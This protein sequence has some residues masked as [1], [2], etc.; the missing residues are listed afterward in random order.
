M[1]QGAIIYFQ[2]QT[3]QKP[4]EII[5]L[6]QVIDIRREEEQRIN[7]TAPPNKKKRKSV[8]IT[9]ADKPKDWVHV[10]EIHT[11]SRVYRL[12]SDEYDVKE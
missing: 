1:D 10:L 7:M 12:F 5:P 2:S 6:S 9:V 3:D 11:T 4:S 8:I